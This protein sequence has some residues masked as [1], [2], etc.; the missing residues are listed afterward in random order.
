MEIPGLLILFGAFV[1]LVFAVATSGKD[2]S[3]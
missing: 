3:E 1:F 2:E